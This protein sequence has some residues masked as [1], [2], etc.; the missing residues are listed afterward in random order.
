MRV[1]K[2][3]LK[4]QVL[5]DINQE[6]DS[7]DGMRVSSQDGGCSPYFYQPS[8]QDGHQVRSRLSIGIVGR[9]FPF[10]LRLGFLH[11]PS[12]STLIMGKIMSS[13]DDGLSPELQLSFTTSVT[14]PKGPRRSVW[15]FTSSPDHTIEDRNLS[16]ASGSYLSRPD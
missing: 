11:A 9:S 6:N 8:D 3:Q 15:S 1:T 5:T 7:R 12:M 16:T 4:T 14:G 13:S 2:H 10:S